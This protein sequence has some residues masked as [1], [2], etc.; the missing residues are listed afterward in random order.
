M[1]DGCTETLNPSMKTLLVCVDNEVNGNT[2]KGIGNG[3][4]SAMTYQQIKAILGDS[5]HGETE[6]EE[7]NFGSYIG[8]AVRGDYRYLFWW[9]NDPTKTTAR[10][11]YIHISKT[12]LDWVARAASAP[13][14]KDYV[15]N[16]E[17]LF[18][19]HSAADLATLRAE[20]KDVPVHKSSL[21]TTVTVDE[22]TTVEYYESAVYGRPEKKNADGDKRDGY[23]AEIECYDYS[24]YARCL[25]DGKHVTS[26]CVWSDNKIMDSTCTFT[27]NITNELYWQDDDLGND[28][29]YDAYR[30]SEGDGKNYITRVTINNYE[31][32][33]GS[34]PTDVWTVALF[35][36]NESAPIV[37]RSC[38]VIVS[39]NGEK[40]DEV[41]M[42]AGGK[43]YPS[44][45]STLKK[46]VE[47]TRLRGQYSEEWSLYEYSSNM[48]ILGVA[49]NNLYGTYTYTVYLVV[50]DCLVSFYSLSEC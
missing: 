25:S 26:Y 50:G 34:I 13:G 24:V 30:L 31:D 45:L 12:G 7:D 40:Y 44:V 20:Y 1:Y 27:G 2:G 17:A 21:L 28:L 16:N 19:E 23:E 46:P 41:I 32:S 35:V 4:N 10:P 47:G 15:K 48:R 43:T 42:F 5:L 37:T 3:M 14:A 9:R 29:A 33:T 49:S 8:L 38:I 36:N 22:H 18:L 39:N 11:D 6:L